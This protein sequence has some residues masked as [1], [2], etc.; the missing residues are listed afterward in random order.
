M[1][2]GTDHSVMGA[3][4][5]GLTDGLENLWDNPKILLF[6]YLFA[7]AMIPVLLVLGVVWVIFAII[8]LIGP[9]L[10]R[11]L[12]A[13]LIKPI[14]VGGLLGLAGAGF[15]GTVS[16]S[17]LK[18]GITENFI[19]LAGVF[20]LKELFL[21][22]FS[23]L[24]V[25]VLFMVGGLGPALLGAAMQNPESASAVA[26]GGMV[27][28]FGLLLVFALVIVLLYVIFQFADVAV[29]LTDHG[30]VDA[31]KKS[32]SLVKDGPLSVLGYTVMRGILASVFFIPAFVSFVLVEPVS[33]V[34]LWIGIALYVLAL[35]AAAAASFSYHAAY[36]GH[37]IAGS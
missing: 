25:I 33:E 26:G 9:L 5:N 29:V 8:P 36:Y 13:G 32:W 22:V 37:R 20:L 35:P 17:S 19:S 7:A 24:A 3:T 12:T 28:V 16:L 21:F 10:T 1:R 14:V 31:Y 6:T 27:L 18:E 2:C 34:F 11:L 4:I 30:V 15:T 23:I